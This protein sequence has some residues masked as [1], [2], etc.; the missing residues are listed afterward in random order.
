MVRRITSGRKLET[1]ARER[2]A[3]RRQAQ[4]IEEAAMQAAEPTIIRRG[5]EDLRAFSTPDHS[6]CRI[7]IAS[8]GGGGFLRAI[9]QGSALRRCASY[10]SVCFPT[11]SF[12]GSPAE[13][14]LRQRH[15]EHNHTHR[16]QPGLKDRQRVA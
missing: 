9:G 13:A 14:Q 5:M 12:G 6:D 11:L 10:R 4:A 15:H 7:A 1:G 3:L 2:A 16:S 8:R